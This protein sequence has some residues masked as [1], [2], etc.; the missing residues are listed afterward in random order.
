MKTKVHVPRAPSALLS[1]SEREKVFLEV[2]IQNMTTESL[3]FEAIKF[4]CVDGWL[5]EDANITTDSVDRV[6]IF[7]G[8][9]AM[10]HPQDLRQ[11][12]YILSRKDDARPSIPV[13]HPPG[14]VIP[15]GRLDISWRSPFGGPG[16]LLTSVRAWTSAFQC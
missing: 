1:K 13:V 9:A 10:M 2:H 7:E 8:D 14:T 11:Y 15:L 5:F 4:E 3:W 6:N 16:R 12:L